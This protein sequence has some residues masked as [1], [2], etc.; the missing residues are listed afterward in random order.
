MQ[1]I[2]GFDH[3]RLEWRKKIHVAELGRGFDDDDDDDIYTELHIIKSFFKLII[4]RV[5]MGSG[6]YI[7]DVAPLA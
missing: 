5:N 4:S 2:L 7:I 3:D 6:P 1:L